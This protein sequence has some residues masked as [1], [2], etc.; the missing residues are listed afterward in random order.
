[1]PQATFRVLILEDDDA[2]VQAMVAE[3]RHAGFAPEW[4]C[5]G[6]ESDYLARLEEKPDLILAD[7]ALPGLDALR[8]LRQLQERGFDIPFIVVTSTAN[9]EVAVECMKVGAADYLLKDRLVR[10][11]PAV[12][13]ALQQKRL[14]E[15]KVRAAM[16]LQESR[17]EIAAVLDSLPIPTVLIDPVLVVQKVNRAAEL[18]AGRSADH[19]IGASLAEALGCLLCNENSGQRA[20]AKAPCPISLAVSDTFETGVGRRQLEAKH[21]FRIGDAAQEKTIV[22]DTAPV[23]VSGREWV[24]L[25]LQDHTEHRA[26]QDQFL[27][28]QKMEAVG[29]LA[30]G[31][32]HD[33][34]NVITVING[35]SELL[36]EK[37]PPK[38]P[39]REDIRQILRAGQSA[40]ALTQQLLTLS[41]KH[42]TVPEPVDINTTVTNMERM[43]R[44]LLGEDIQ[45]VTFVGHGLGQVEMDP[46]HLEQVIMNLAVNA[47]DAMP[48][49]GT[50]TIEAGR[51]WMV[52]P[53][54][55]ALDVKPGR[56]VVLTVRDTGCGMDKE[57]A[58]RVF[59]PFF[60]TKEHEKG[61]GLGLSTVYGVV[62]QARGA[63]EL[64]TEPTKG[65]TFRVY[66][67][68]VD[69]GKLRAKSQRVTPLELTGSETVLVVEDDQALRTLTSRVLREHGY[70]VIEAANGGEALLICE[71]RKEN[72][73]LLLTDAVMPHMSGGELAERLKGLVPDLKVVYMSGYTVSDIVDRG[74]QEENIILVPKPF[75]PRK[76]LSAV[77]E[78]LDG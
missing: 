28:A 26:V 65:T 77:R 24:L 2:D 20:S 63:L 50:L 6:T 57:T 21:P 11:G 31:M 3:L 37:L 66:L 51:E 25:C 34:N 73:N 64:D 15:E 7:Y 10:L 55:G 35:Y 18:F 76:L 47:R 12:A 16:A 19:M 5:V 32:A 72:V 45:L 70:T 27:H 46:G 49:G 9:E 52:N 74:V 67:P 75:S 68:R 56:F 8:A 14:R 53:K 23:R 42:I 62:R 36:L 78:V 40:A 61:T 39:A 33:F 4:E 44:R 13:R 30:G 41:R 22:M 54:A 58:D 71:R 17:E 48:Q 1:M 59:E 69:T 60:T 38:N 43:L 29:R